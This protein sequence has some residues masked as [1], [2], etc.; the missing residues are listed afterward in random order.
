M[1]GSCFLPLLRSTLLRSA[2]KSS[3]PL[4][5]RAFV[6]W[7]AGLGAYLHLAGAGTGDTDGLY[8]RFVSQT[9]S[10]L[11]AALI[12]GNA[13]MLERFL[14]KG[15]PAPAIGVPMEVVHGPLVDDAEDNAVV[16]DVAAYPPHS[17]LGFDLLVFFPF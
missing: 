2:L 9:F 11:N 10:R 1:I 13:H 7:L 17:S 4:G 15:N 3:G 6:G 14:S 5:S 8:S 16:A 12:K